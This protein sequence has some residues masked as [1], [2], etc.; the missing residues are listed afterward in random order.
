[1]AGVLLMV[2]KGW[3]CVVNETI[4]GKANT[5]RAKISALYS[6]CLA[7]LQGRAFVNAT[8]SGFRC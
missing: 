5:E 7:L 6:V 4:D 1:M 8:S 3:R 2:P